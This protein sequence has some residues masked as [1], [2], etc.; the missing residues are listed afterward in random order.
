[1]VLRN[2]EKEITDVKSSADEMSRLFHLKDWAQG[3]L[4][5]QWEEK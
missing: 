5:A 3:D 1:M 2:K 4:E